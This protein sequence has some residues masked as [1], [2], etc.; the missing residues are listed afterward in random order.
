[1]NPDGALAK[2]VFLDKD[3]TL[4]EN[5]PY[6]VDP[7][8]MR[9][10]PR[11]PEA[12]SLLH[13]EGFRL[14]VVSNQSGVAR[15]YFPEEALAEV[16]RGL[17]ALLEPHGVPLAAVYFCPHHRE[18]VVQPY[19]VECEC[20]KPMPG[21]LLAACRDQGVDPASSWMIGDILHDV[22]AGRRAGSRTIL[23]DNGH[24]TE[25]V[26]SSLRTPH[27]VARDL[28]EAAHVVLGRKEAPGPAPLSARS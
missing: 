1:M 9:L 2:A 25:W 4:V 24:E 5:V 20:R 13:D 7:R 11:A 17:R 8:R 18:G 26:L 15:G 21:L 27:A 10:M 16:E 19:A 28:L 3:G 22:E 23:V 12:L 6:N 14:I